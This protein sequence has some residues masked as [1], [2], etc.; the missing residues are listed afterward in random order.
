MTKP[1]KPG[2][3]DVAEP[4]EPTNPEEPGVFVPGLKKTVYIRAE[5]DLPYIVGSSGPIV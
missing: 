1:E 2:D 3:G 4:T 5:L